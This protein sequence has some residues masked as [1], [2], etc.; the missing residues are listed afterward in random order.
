ME[1]VL[2][3]S[4]PFKTKPPRTCESTGRKRL[5]LIFFRSSYGWLVLV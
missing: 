1:Q 2:V 5:L 3:C 4:D